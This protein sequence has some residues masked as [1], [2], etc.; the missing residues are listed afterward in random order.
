MTTLILALH[1]GPDAAAAIRT[2]CADAGRDVEVRSYIVNGLSS[3]YHAFAASI[4]RDGRILPTLAAKLGAAQPLDAYE[5]V[6]LVTWSAPYALVEDVLAIK[7]DAAALTGFVALDSGYGTP[8]PG[9]VDYARRAVNGECLYYATY[10]DVPTYT[11]PSTGDFLAAVVQHVGEPDGLF[12]VEHLSHDAAALSVAVHRGGDSVGAFWRGEHVRAQR[13]GPARV[14]AALAALDGV[15]D[16]VK[17]PPVAQE[18]P[19]PASAPAQGTLRGLGLRALAL[20]KA[21]LAARVREAPAGSNRGTEVDRYLDGCVRGGKRLGVRGVPWCAAFA[22]W[23]V[24]T[25]AYG[26]DGPADALHW[27]PATAGTDPPIGYRASVTELFAD[28]WATGA[29]RDMQAAETPQPGDLVVMRRDGE[30]P[31]TGGKGHVEI[32]SA[33]LAD[34]SLVSIGGNVADRVSETPRHLSDL[35]GWIRLA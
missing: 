4:K 12:D 10:T 25:A 7:A 8:T 2:A 35:V 17:A 14:L 20:A 28:A 16:T 11:Y 32:V 18:A 24:W 22:S 5:R 13:R 6:L 34:G 1:H 9:V 21:A 30:D 27:T 19:A 15:A 33:H 29:W 23:C 31:R 3:A 26:D